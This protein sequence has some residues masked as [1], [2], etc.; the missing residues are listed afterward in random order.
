MPAHQTCFLM[1]QITENNKKW[2][3][4]VSKGGPKIHQKSL[5][6]HSGTFKGPSQRICDPIDCKMIPKWCPK[7]SKWSK[8]GHLGTLKR[9]QKSTQSD[10]RVYSKQICTLRFYPLISILEI[11]FSIPA[12]PCS[13]QIS[14]QLVAR[15]AGGRGEA[16][17]YE[18]LRRISPE[19]I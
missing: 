2:S 18:Y 14:S 16:L 8:N 17:R 1:P 7:T 11:S 13:L 10:P 19:Y 6:I 9:S 15:G 12:N 4:L 3:K 5:K